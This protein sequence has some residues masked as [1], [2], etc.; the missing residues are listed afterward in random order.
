VY[1]VYTEGM[2]LMPIDTETNR[3][4]KPITVPADDWIWGIA[5]S[6]DGSTAYVADLGAGGEEV[7]PVNLH[8]GK[9][10][11]PFNVVP[12]IGEIAITP[13]GTT[14]YMASST[15]DVVVPVNLATRAIGKPIP[16]GPPGTPEMPGPDAPWAIAITPDG[17]TA[18]VTDVGTNTVTPI[19]LA[20][21]TPGKP[22]P[23]GNEPFGIA[24]APNG[25]TAYVTN[26]G[27]PT[28]TGGDT[29]TPIN[30]ATNTAGK[31]IKV[32]KYP[33]GIAITPGGGTAYVANGAISA[34]QVSTVTPIDLTTGKPG[35]AIKA[36]SGS[37]VV[38]SPTG[39]TAYVSS[40]GHFVTPISTKTNK[41]GK[42]IRMARP[43]TDMA[44]TPGWYAQAHVPS[45]RT[46]TAPA[47]C[48]FRG[49]IY[50]AF[51]ISGGAI[52]YA[53]RV[54]SGWSTVRRIGG[55]WGSAD[56]SSAPALVGIANKLYAFWTAKA[57]GEIE[58]STLTGTSWSSPHTVG[59]TWGHAVTSAAP[60][61]T[62]AGAMLH[63]AWKAAKSRSILS[64]TWAGSSWST[65]QVV[66]TDA[67]SDAPAIAPLPFPANGGSPVVIA[68]TDHGSRIG[69]GELTAQGFRTL[70]VVPQ[71][72]TK[73]APALTYAGTATDGTLYVAWRRQATGQIGYKAIFHALSSPLAPADW[74]AQEFEPQALTS[75][76]PALAADYYTIYIA[77]KGKS[78]SQLG[79][80]FAVN[81]Y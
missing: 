12:N 64:S 73:A 23:V 27:G 72:N 35:K 63:V 10:Q 40:S 46:S 54:P 43:P 14:A 49:T 45:A 44:V 4:E 22:I 51:R 57:T 7:V 20:T 65:Q 11:K 71:A 61:V 17:D 80:S 38:V 67:T 52:G 13:N 68:W 47:L 79:Y 74:T 3:A 8:T 5:I 69:Y 2:R 16:I 32:G 6:P 1:A 18:Y 34:G 70:G 9:P 59:G 76:G 62:A 58:Y 77:W 36:S 55:G 50:A 33:Y 21:G 39:T 24:I 60:A 42:R 28:E 26:S 15:N 53:S 66:V 41:P 31:P 30:L 78:T 29:V 48:A 19:N 56:T 81:P 37:G 75:T 25:K